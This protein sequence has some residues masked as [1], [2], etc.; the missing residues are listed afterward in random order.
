MT[1]ILIHFIFIRDDCCLPGYELLI[2]FAH[3]FAHHLH[4]PR[5]Q[6]FYW[7]ACGHQVGIC[8]SP[9]PFVARILFVWT[10]GPH[11][12]FNH[13]KNT[14]KWTRLVGLTWGWSSSPNCTNLS[15]TVWPC[16]QPRWECVENIGLIFKIIS[17]RVRMKSPIGTLHA[18]WDSTNNSTSLHKVSALICFICQICGFLLHLAHLRRTTS[19]SR[20]LGTD[21]S[22][23][24][25]WRWR[26]VQCHGDW[27]ARPFIGGAPV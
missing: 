8:Q 19:E 15:P 3:F 17:C 10:I 16:C 11:K 6:H 14:G 26:G 13:A 27:F 9:T 22:C 1:V 25:V 21:P 7:R 4:C 18:H 5:Y 12:W 20:C 24:L 2:C 23:S